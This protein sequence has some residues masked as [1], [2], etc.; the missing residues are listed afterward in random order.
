MKQ[1]DFNIEVSYNVYTTDKHG[2]TKRY[3]GNYPCMCVVKEVA[4]YIFKN[5]GVECSYL[6]RIEEI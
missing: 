1:K 4:D 2:K 5:Y 3:V 6:K